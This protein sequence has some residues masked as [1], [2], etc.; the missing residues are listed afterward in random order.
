MGGHGGFANLDDEARAQH[1]S[2]DD[3]ARVVFL[4]AVLA[5]V[6][7][8]A[9]TALRYAVDLAAEHTLDLVEHGK[10]L[11]AGA[12]VL[13]LGLGG[14]V[15]GILVKRPGWADAA[16]DGMEVALGN[17]HVTYHYDGDDPQPRYDKP[18][19]S[20]ALRKSL[21]T[22]ITLGTGGSGGLE[23]PSVV[24]GESLAAG[25][26]RVL[27][28]RSEYELRTYQLA[29]IAAAVATLLGAPFTA[30]LFSIE[31]AYGDRIIY[32]KFA[33]A[34][35]AALIA[36]V[37][38]TRLHGFAPIFSAPAHTPVYR[39]SEYAATAL[40]AVA[41][42]APVALAFG[43]IMS[44]TRALA[45]QRHPALT[46]AWTAAGAGLVAI[47]LFW[48]AHLA[49]K[50]VLG[51]GEATL[52]GLFAH[53]PALAAP[54]VLVLAVLGKM[55]T[56][57][58]TVGGGGSAGILVPSMYLGGVS[59]ALTAMLLS[60]VG[61]FPGLDPSLFAVVGIAS[62]LVAVIG[63]PLAAIALVLEVFGTP[64]GPPAILACGVTY[65]LT[66]R[67]RIYKNQRMSPDPV[68]DERG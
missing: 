36:Y 1:E 67:M 2:W 6:V 8:A 59:G 24:V 20:L 3:I 39:T 55:L 4:A 14:V 49:P 46:G 48:G 60:S 23:A 51:M 53:D 41:V 52:A 68:A 33:Y 37:L 30:A 34:L 50:H 45:A 43:Q 54:W 18:A 56:T 10:W 35:F 12:L 28:V 21:M 31:V 26:S 17:Y 25:F 9:C 19:F 65:L 44:R 63:V 42:S 62:A 22:F 15:R 47:G 5:V 29:A 61:L 40:V 16:G 7:W 11:G 58:L 57:G 38:N 13:A 66:L 64:Y 27:R 32:R